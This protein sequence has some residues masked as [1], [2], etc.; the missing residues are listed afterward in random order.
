MSSQSAILPDS[1]RNNRWRDVVTST[2][3]VNRL[4]K[5]KSFKAVFGQRSL[6]GKFDLDDVVRDETGAAGQAPFEHDGKPGFDVNSDVEVRRRR[7]NFVV[8]SSEARNFFLEPHVRF[9]PSQFLRTA[10]YELVPIPLSYFV[11]LFM[12]TAVFGH[13]LREARQAAGCRQKLPSPVFPGVATFFRVIPG[14]WFFTNMAFVNE[15]GFWTSF[16]ASIYVPEV[17]EYIEP[18]ECCLLYTSPSPRD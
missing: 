7:G 4:N 8:Y 12:E 18:L 11:V 5:R 17:R 1:Q 15:V 16:L 14:S 3:F 2:N 13:S 9:K 10:L 6:R